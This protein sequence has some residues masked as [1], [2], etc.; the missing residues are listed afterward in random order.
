MGISKGIE[1][2]LGWLG[3]GQQPYESRELTADDVSEIESAAA[4]YHEDG[5]VVLRTRPP[6]ESDGIDAAV[7]LLRAVHDVE[8]E[9]GISNESAHHAHEIYSDGERVTFHWAAASEADADRFDRQ[10]RAA[11]DGV[12]V[13]EV[14]RGFPTV[15][16][17][18]YA[19]AATARLAR[20]FWY[21]LQSPLTA[22]VDGEVLADP[23]ADVIADATGTDARD[24]CRVFVQTVF[25][26]ARDSWSRGG[27]WGHDVSVTAYE[28]RETHQEQSLSGGVRTVEPTPREQKLGRLMEQQAGAAGFYVTMRVFAVASDP[29]T[30]ER[31]VRQIAGDYEGY[32]H[33]V[34]EQAVVP[35]PI[36]PRAVPSLL[37]DAAGRDHEVS[38]FDRL[39]R[40][41]ER[42][43]LVTAAELA[44][45]CH[46][47]NAAINAPSVDW[48][49]MDA[50]PGVPPETTQ[51]EDVIGA[52]GSAEGTAE[53]DRFQ[54]LS[55]AD[56]DGGRGSEDPGADR[57][58]DDPLDGELD[59]LFEV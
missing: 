55:A 23:Y 47:P 44:G 48:A 26:P 17:G 30:A 10:V 45:L 32:T 58:E 12:T 13:D 20:P 59:D 39:T 54:P 25:E 24:D 35:A 2:L 40:F 1:G 37:R 15:E 29:E 21:P 7:S 19:A 27:P 9:L 49:N 43:F 22:A 11:Y 5:G 56:A 34:T 6:R 57:D 36:S 46:L 3:V 4:D 33:P 18:E 52:D 42:K 31:R 8:V 51:M 14:D 28:L 41:N 53:A 38:A 50:G 16:P